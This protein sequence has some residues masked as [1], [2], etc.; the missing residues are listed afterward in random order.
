[1]T[2]SLLFVKVIKILVSAFLFA[3]YLGLDCSVEIVCSA[4]PLFPVENY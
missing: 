2:I 3:K 4:L 1:M